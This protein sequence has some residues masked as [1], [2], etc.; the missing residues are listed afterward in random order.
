M[1]ASSLV[2]LVVVGRLGRTKLLAAAAVWPAL[3]LAAVAVGPANLL[4]LALQAAE[5]ELLVMALRAVIMAQRAGGDGG[6]GLR[7]PNRLLDNQCCYKYERGDPHH[8][9]S[10]CRPLGS[11]NHV[12]GD[13]WE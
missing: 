10:I 12:L 2:R 8:T 6:R 7:R 5:A 9:P 1:S 3:L 4:L 11:L 13:H